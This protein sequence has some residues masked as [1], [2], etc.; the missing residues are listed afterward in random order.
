M[1]IDWVSPS[2]GPE[3]SFLDS[4]NSRRSVDRGVFVQRVSTTH[5]VWTPLNGEYAQ[6]YDTSKEVSS[7]DDYWALDN[8]CGIMKYYEIRLPDSTT[9]TYTNPTAATSYTTQVGATATITFTGTGLKFSSYSD[10]RGGIWRFV[11]NG[12]EQTVDLSVYRESQGFILQDM[13]SG[14]SYGEHTVVATYQGDDPENP[15]SGG[16]SRGWIS[17][18][19]V[20]TSNAGLYVKAFYVVGSNQPNC[21]HDQMT[22]THTKSILATAPSHKEFAFSCRALSGTTA[23]QNQFIPNHSA[24]DT[25]TASIFDNVSTDRTMRI[26]GGSDLLAS[27][28]DQYTFA[29]GGTAC[30]LSEVYGGVNIDDDDLPLFDVINTYTWTVD[31]LNIYSKLTSL[32]DLNTST[33][34]LSMFD[35]S[36]TTQSHAIT[37]GQEIDITQDTQPSQ[38]TILDAG[39]EI[40]GWDGNA[41]SVKKT[42][43]DF[44]KSLCQAMSIQSPVAALKAGS[45][46]LGDL[47]WIGNGARGKIYPRVVSNIAIPQGEVFEW[48]TKFTLGIVPDAYN[49][50]S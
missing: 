18:D 37:A 41:L 33:C 5:R 1:G 42:G 50:L 3:S 44:E 22:V 29:E 25:T 9:G 38:P 26:D 31:G 4:I 17:R 36:A 16:T 15:P 8:A 48:N 19:N 14:I 2:P 35:V 20:T 7:A 47:T 39:E 34:Y 28:T 6:F 10:N 30:V 13:F 11:L 32:V 24:I 43:T 49:T 12:G 45:E 27:L 21:C 40:S 46:Y 23:S